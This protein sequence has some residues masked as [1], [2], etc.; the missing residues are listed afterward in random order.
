MNIIAKRTLVDFYTKHPETEQALKSWY[1]I[2]KKANWEKSSDIQSMFNSAD[3]IQGNIIVFNICGNNYRLIVK[4]N[5]LANTGYIKFIGTHKQY[6][7]LKID[8]L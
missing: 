5:Y 1:L 4:F 2:V 6:G 3:S 8:Q 7:K